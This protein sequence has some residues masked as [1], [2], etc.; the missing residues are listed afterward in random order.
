MTAACAIGM[1]EGEMN[2]FFVRLEKC[3][4]DFFAAR[5]KELKKKKNTQGTTDP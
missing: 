2:E 1:T 3:W 4:K 5:E